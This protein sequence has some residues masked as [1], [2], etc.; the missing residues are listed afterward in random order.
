[1]RNLSSSPIMTDVTASGSGGT[2]SYGVANF[3][4]SPIMT[5]VTALGSGGTTHN[6]GVANFASSSPIMTNVTATGI[7]GTTSYGV[8]NSGSSPT[9]RGSTIG[10]TVNYGIYNIGT[11]GTVIV[12]GSQIIGA[13]TINNVSAYVVNVGSS[14]LS[15]GAVIGA[16]TFVCAA[17]YDEAYALL[18]ANCT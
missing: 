15:G 11:P 8:Y 17:S 7:G 3:T 6:I 10:G 1:M 9:I 5:N 12:D 18:A 16:G 4:S 14:L 13:N 2:F